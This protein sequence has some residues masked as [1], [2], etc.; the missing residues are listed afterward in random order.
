MAALSSAAE[1]EREAVSAALCGAVVVHPVPFDALSVFYCVLQS[2]PEPSV[3]CVLIVCVLIV[4]LVRQ[5]MYIG[6]L[7]CVWM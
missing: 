1:A 4:C 7:L 3:L 2:V 5:Q 6:H